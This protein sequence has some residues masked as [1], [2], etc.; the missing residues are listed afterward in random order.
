MSQSPYLSHDITRT[1]RA[2]G[3]Y[4]LTSNTP[5]G[6]VVDKTTD[7][8]D[9]WAA[10]TPDALF[11]AERSGPGWREM[12]Y[13]ET[14]EQT[15][16]MAGGLLGLGLTSETPILIIS[17]NSVDHALLTLAAQ[18][19]GIP[20]VPV[21]EQYALIP[22]ARVQLD[23]VAGLVKPGAVFAEDGD[24]LAEVLERDCFAGMRKL[25]SQG[26][27]SGSVT[28]AELTAKGGDITEAARAVGPESVAKILMTSGSTSSPKGVLT[29]HRMMC[30]NQT[31]IAQ[32][33]PFLTA[34]PP[35][36]VDWLPWNHVFGGSH[37]FNMI[38]ANGGSLY[39]DGGK[40]VPALVGK[41]I[42]NLRLQ[43]GTVTF[44]VP[45]GFA[46]LR[47]VMRDDK[48]LRR[49]Y[50]QDLDML[51]YAGASLP[52]DVWTD[53]E[54]MAREV[55]GDMPLFT[56]SWG[57]TETA[58]A[59]LLQH[60]PTHRSGVIGVPLPGIEVKLIPDEDKRCE[61]RVRGPNIFDGYFA[62]P[63]KTAD[64][65]DEDGFFLTGDAMKFV[66]F[67][68][69]N[70][71]L[72]FDGRISEDFKL[73]TGTWVRAANLRLEVLAALGPH[74]ADLVIT[75]ADRSEIGVLIVPSQSLRDAEGVTEDNG[76]LIVPGLADVLVKALS[77]A[78]AGSS[79]RIA[80]ALV[81]AEPPQLTDGEITA[82]GNLNL[83]KI[84]TR[85]ADLLERLYSDD[86]AATILI[87]KG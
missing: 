87:P 83:R 71:G 79:T 40:P 31:Q 12:S 54:D 57:L 30:T 73:M 44:N 18:Y 22:P 21:A 10:E 51:F 20:T 16:A 47:D 2:D 86:D 78:T 46:K 48:E 25:T 1:E 36:I 67:D 80:R 33:L 69:P 50:F 65:F 5:L 42:E 13:A 49:A 4:L 60:E 35:V 24:A 53:L 62:D 3:T 6:T 77:N 39:V 29:T 68:T 63:V 7:W 37:N 19:V 72:L 82:K 84:Q 8:L 45:V 26:G 55:R 38:L 23:Y 75:G 34:K 56:S 43:T 17:G 41:T 15:R 14:Q 27:P 59:T 9:K 58:P 76:A 52:Q 64:S 66:D 70:L 85:R 11:I 74:A 61:V 81:M 32:A 28:L